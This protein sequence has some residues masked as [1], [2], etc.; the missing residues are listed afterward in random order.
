MFGSPICAGGVCTVDDLARALAAE[1]LRKPAAHDDP[2]LAF[3][4]LPVNGIHARRADLY[5]DVAGSQGRRRHVPHVDDVIP[6]ECMDHDRFHGFF[7]SAVRNLVT[8][9][10]SIHLSAR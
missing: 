4:G 1:D 7:S 6:A 3:P 5:Q 8:L 10:I 2:R 9:L